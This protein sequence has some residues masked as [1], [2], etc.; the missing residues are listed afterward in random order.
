MRD[1]SRT[2]RGSPRQGGGYAGG[3]EKRLPSNFNRLRGLS[4]GLG[5]IRT[6]DPLIRSQVLY[7]TELPVRG[8][9]V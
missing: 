9:G 4:G 5:R 6:P 7:P 8:G 1:I 3:G 2:F